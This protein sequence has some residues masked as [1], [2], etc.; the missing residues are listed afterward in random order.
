MPIAEI[1]G[2][3]KNLTFFENF[4][5]PF[6]EKEMRNGPASRKEAEKPK[7]ISPGNRKIGRPETYQPPLPAFLPRIVNRVKE[8]PPKV[9]RVW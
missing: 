6:P 2:L 3:E 1:G 7:K 8:T 9:H 4:A 5:P